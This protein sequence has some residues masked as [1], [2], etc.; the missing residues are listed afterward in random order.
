MHVLDSNN[1]TISTKTTHKIIIDNFRPHYDSDCE[2]F[3]F[4][5]CCPV[6]TINR[7]LNTNTVLRKRARFYYCEILNEFVLD[8]NGEKQH[9]SKELDDFI[10]DHFSYGFYRRRMYTECLLLFTEAK[11]CEF[12]EMK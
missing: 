12:R 8:I 10:Q 1:N 9:I 2:C 6:C 11:T 7:A 5:D 4:Q 3:S